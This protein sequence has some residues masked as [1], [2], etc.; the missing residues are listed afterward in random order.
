[1]YQLRRRLLTLFRMVGAGVTGLFIRKR[2]S[3]IVICGFPRSGTSL[4]YNMMSATLVDYKHIKGEKPC[5]ELLYEKGCW[6]SKNPN[7]LFSVKK[8]YLR[9]ARRKKLFFLVIVRDP[10]DVMTSKHQIYRDGY[11]IGYEGSINGSYGLRDLYEQ[12]KVLLADKK[13]SNKIFFTTY[14]ELVEDSEALQARFSMF[15]GIDFDGDWAEFHSSGGD[16]AYSPGEQ[17]TGE[18]AAAPLQNDRVC[19]WKNDTHRARICQQFTDYP[20]L[21]D[22]LVD[23]GYEDD[24]NWFTEYSVAKE[25]E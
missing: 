1:M 9:N 5:L 6:I 13:I 14:E 22:V 19:K 7:D 18:R 16:L 10:R 4:L 11:F 2:E 21:F 17:A 8:A 25:S 23:L 12:Y 15:T 3:H 24:Q 20:Q